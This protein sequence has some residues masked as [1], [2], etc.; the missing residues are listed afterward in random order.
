MKI[1]VEIKTIFKNAKSPLKAT[2]T[3]VLDDCL[4]IKNVKLIETEEKGLFISMPSF[5]G[6]DGEWRSVC[7]PITPEL[8]AEL[9]TAL[10]EAYRQG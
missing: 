9:Q 4:A 10:I 2:A 6:R 8:R 1:T 5:R 7:H 3:V